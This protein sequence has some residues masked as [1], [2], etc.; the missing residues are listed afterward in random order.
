MRPN[1]QTL[2]AQLLARCEEELDRA[3]ARLDNEAPMDLDEIEEIALK[4]R[5]K[6]S[7]EITQALAARASAAPVHPPA[8]PECGQMCVYKGEKS[9]VVRTRSGDICLKRAHYY[10]PQCHKG[11]FP[12]G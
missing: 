12:P 7:A 6:I 11:F 9:K 2:K 8:C 4:A 1:K 5:A 10:C 3:L